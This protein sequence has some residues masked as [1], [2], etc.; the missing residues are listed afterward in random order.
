MDSN[1]EI[2]EPPEG[3][4]HDAA[5]FWR[6]AHEA[7]PLND[8]ERT[9]LAQICK[10][11][12]KVEELEAA[13]KADGRYTINGVQGSTVIHPLF[14]EIRAQL[15]IINTLYRTL[16]LHDIIGELPNG[17]KTPA[18]DPNVIDMIERARNRRASGE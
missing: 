8:H 10:A 9:L 3:I 11:L 4:S 17:K 13:F 12:T 1:V 2:P 16:K 6:H 18:A 7:T 14:T 5:D 15:N